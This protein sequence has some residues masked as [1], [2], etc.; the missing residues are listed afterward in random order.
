MFVIGTNGTIRAGLA[1][2]L[3]GVALLA[4]C[5]LQHGPEH[6]FKTDRWRFLSP[7]KVIRPPEGTPIS[8]IILNLTPADQSTELPAHAEFPK[9][10]D[11]V[12]EKT[13][14]RIGPTDVVDI[15]ILD[16]L[17]EGMETVVR[18]EVS[19]TGYID[20]PQLD[21]RVLAEGLTK[22]E[23]KQAIINAYSPNILRDPK[24]S[25]T[26]VARRQSVF[27][28]LGA[29]DRAGT[30][31]ISRRDMRLLE[32]LALAGEQSPS[33][34][35]YIYVI[36]QPR[37]KASGESES[38]SPAGLDDLPELPELP[39]IEPEG[40]DAAEEPSPA[41]PEAEP[42]PADDIDRSLQELD[43]SLDAAPAPSEIYRLSETDGAAP[44]APA[45]E[46][47]TAATESGPRT[48]KW[49]YS[50][51]KWR[52]VLMEG[53]E[54]AEPE[55]VEDFGRPVR[56]E[57]VPVVEKQAMD[58]TDGE[59]A[60]PFGWSQVDKSKLT[61]VIAI[62][63]R[64]LR[65][66]NPRMNIVIREND[67]IHVPQLEIGEF[68]VTGEVRSPGVYSLTGRRMTVKQA[69][70]A[71]GSLGPFAWPNNAVVYRRV[72]D[73]EEQMIPIDVE[74][75]FQGEAPDFLVKKDDII[76]VGTSVE[77]TFYAVIRNAFRMT[78]GFGFIYDK[79]F[80][81]PQFFTPTSRR[82]TRL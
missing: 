71:A 2:M 15:S 59:P 51:G 18:R 7:D 27:S 68:Y 49:V 32:A 1:L 22:G 30:Y 11:Y 45:G 3:A 25:V 77:A 61:R 56:P 63:M 13:D 10:E 42:S 48:Y 69:I 14:Y 80:A 67:V 62:D 74:A 82:F 72:G 55:D 79:N 65:E 26:V 16:L 50:N 41:E 75:I 28:V 33:L 21:E 6:A 58:E 53:Q 12:Y 19:D 46:E 5:S 20:L 43:D 44:A 78:Y 36:R 81:D 66:G 35:R 17:N 40:Q 57:G 29:V 31:N 34:L 4:G 8:P 39:P 54:P 24:V 70:S 64:K 9:P 60:D 38:A 23:L 37:P 73:N 47:T 52:R 76:A